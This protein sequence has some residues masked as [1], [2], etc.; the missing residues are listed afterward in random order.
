MHFIIVQRKPNIIVE[1]Y[2]QFK[3]QFLIDNKPE[4]FVY[5]ESTK[6]N[7]NHKKNS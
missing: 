6:K 5:Q 3:E 4:V 7:V 1:T 2:N